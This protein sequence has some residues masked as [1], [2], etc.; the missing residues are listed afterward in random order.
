[1]S[2]LIK[3][4]ELKGGPV[5]ISE[6]LEEFI[7]GDPRIYTIF[8]SLNF[9]IT[10]EYIANTYNLEKTFVLKIIKYFE[11]NNIVYM[12]NKGLYQLSEHATDIYFGQTKAF[13]E[14]KAKL[15]FMQSLSTYHNLSRDPE[16]WSDKDDQ[17]L[18]VRLTHSQTSAVKKQIE[19]LCAQIK[20]MDVMNSDNQQPNCKL[21]T[22]FLALKP[23]TD[24]M[25]KKIVEE[26]NKT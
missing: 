11:K 21:Q 10:A 24:E 22:I 26:S 13:Y 25:L 23:F 1:M 15:F 16:Y 12:P 5:R 3:E 4:A 20:G 8:V 14:L 19:S 17:F 9:P 2:T 6:K 18:L 7:C